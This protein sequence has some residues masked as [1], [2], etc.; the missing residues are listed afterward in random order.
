MPTAASVRQVALW[1]PE[2]VECVTWDSVT[3]RVRGKMFALLHPDEQS[4]TVKA[5]PGEQQA[6]IAADAGTFAPAPYVGR[7]GWVRAQLA[8]V[9]S[10]QLRELLIE[11]WRQTAPKRVVATYSTG[12]RRHGEA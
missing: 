11:A 8:S 10:T 1:L 7:F 3:F 6:L 9:D 12:K 4:V 2:V 5:T